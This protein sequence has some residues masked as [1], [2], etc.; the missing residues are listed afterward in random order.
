[1]NQW[2]PSQALTGMPRPAPL[3]AVQ[4]T[5]KEAVRFGYCIGTLNFLIAEGVLSEVLRSPAIYP[6]P[7]VPAALRG[8]INRQGA[9]IPVWD[10]A[11]VLDCRISDETTG[12]ISESIFRKEEQESVLIL[13]R[14]DDRVGLMIDGLPHAIRDIEKSAR[15]PLLPARLSGHVP[16]ALFADGALWLELNHFTLFQTLAVSQAA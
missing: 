16:A 14:D 6:I 15:L 2:S 3:Q 8:Y 12:L 5:R 4:V 11:G 7:N 10:L 1:M 9:L 13:G